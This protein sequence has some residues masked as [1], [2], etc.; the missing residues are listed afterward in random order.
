MWIQM[1]VFEYYGCQKTINQQFSCGISTSDAAMVQCS[2]SPNKA[3]YVLVV[4]LFCFFFFLFFYSNVL[5]QSGF[6][7]PVHIFQQCYDFEKNVSQYFSMRFFGIF[8]VLFLFASQRF[9]THHS[10][11]IFFSFSPLKIVPKENLHFPLGVISFFVI[12]WVLFS[13]FFFPLFFVVL[14]SF[15]M[16]LEPHVRDSLM[17]PWKKA[18]VVNAILNLKD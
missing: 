12:R 15:P 16:Y 13:G 2:F 9:V 17:I 6:C 4:F 10:S 14:L 3:H 1:P 18:L 5:G 11:R 7:T 8:Y